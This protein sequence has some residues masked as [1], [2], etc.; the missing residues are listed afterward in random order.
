MKEKFL[1]IGFIIKGLSSMKGID[2]EFVPK[3]RFFQIK[4]SVINTMGDNSE[5]IMICFIDIS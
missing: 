1:D 2:E 5:K 4:K 3:F